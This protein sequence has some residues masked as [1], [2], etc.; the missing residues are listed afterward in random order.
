MLS[1]ALAY[2]WVG[3]LW[4]GIILLW[5][6]LL[7]LVRKVDEVSTAVK[8]LVIVMNRDDQTEP[9]DWDELL[10]QLKRQQKG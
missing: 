2:A 1:V 4:A 5:V 9:V 3:P 8:L 6:T 10:T 7:A